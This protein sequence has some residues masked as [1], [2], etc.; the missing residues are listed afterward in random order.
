MPLRHGGF[1][2]LRGRRG[3]RAGAGGRRGT[4]KCSAE[5]GRS[6]HA[7]RVLG[8]K[9]DH[10]KRSDRGE[11]EIKDRYGR[12]AKQRRKKSSTHQDPGRARLVP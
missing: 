7:A 3:A 11:T 12:E 6:E 1:T 4:L 2:R 10:L 5:L 9:W 8:R